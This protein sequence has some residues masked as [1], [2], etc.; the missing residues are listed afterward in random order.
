MLPDIVLVMVLV[1]I[2]VAGIFLWARLAASDART[3]DAPAGEMEALFRGGVMCRYVIT[4]GSARPA[5]VLQL[6]RPAARDADQPLDRSD[7]GSQV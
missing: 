2:C 4:S 5:G 1:L 3:I 6:G 7:L